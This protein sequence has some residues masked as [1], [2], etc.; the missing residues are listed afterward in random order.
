MIADAFWDDKH[1][2]RRS[3]AA[4]MEATRLSKSSVIR[5]T[6]KLE[7]LGLVEISRSV[8]NV[9]SYYLPLFDQL[10]TLPVDNSSPETRVGS[11]PQTPP[12]VSERHL[13]VSDRHRRG[14]TQTPDTSSSRIP[15][16]TPVVKSEAVDNPVEQSSTTR[17]ETS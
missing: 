16:R 3:V 1:F 4:L 5:A 15:R 10:S 11:V 13:V 2:A 17:K 8:N 7:E 12:V 9:N 14:V 6:K